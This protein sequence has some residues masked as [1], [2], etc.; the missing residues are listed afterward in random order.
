MQHR[1]QARNETQ[2]AA[3]RQCL[4]R[5]GRARRLLGVGT[6]RRR[7]ERVGHHD[8]GCGSRCHVRRPLHGIAVYHHQLVESLRWRGFRRDALAAR[9]AQVAGQVEV[10]LG[11]G[12]Q[13]QI[14]GAQ[15]RRRGDVKRRIVRHTVGAIG[16]DELAGPDRMVRRDEGQPAQHHGGEP[17]ESRQHRTDRIGNEQMDELVL[18]QDG[19]PG[20]AA[21]LVGEEIGMGGVA[22]ALA[23]PIDHTA[24]TTMVNMGA[25]GSCG[26]LHP[27]ISAGLPRG[28]SIAG[29][30]CRAVGVA[31]GGNRVAARAGVP[32]ANPVSLT[33]GASPDRPGGRRLGRAF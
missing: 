14:G 4:Q 28:G 21:G 2:D 31:R 22:S 30:T 15:Q 18:L 27:G 24:Q 17:V 25:R 23:R 10:I 8:G 11:A 5:L 3:V 6:G 33:L 9:I 26:A 12:Y 19:G 32:S 29:R 16:D 7:L 20:E 13:A 1:P